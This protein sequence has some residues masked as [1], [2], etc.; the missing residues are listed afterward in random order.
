MNPRVYIS[1]AISSL[2]YLDAYENFEKVEHKLKSIGITN[3]F[4]PMKEIDQ[5]LD[6]DAQMDICEENLRK[7]S[8][9]ILI[10][11]WKQS[12]GA[13]QEFMWANQLGLQIMRDTE[14]DYK[15]LEW[16][17]S[18]QREIIVEEL[19]AKPA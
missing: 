1:G 19:K 16:R 8:I 18:S 13:K 15:S 3:I 2:T 7:C 14:N 10:E 5:M 6:Y 17:L 4:N 9:I 12:K 11:N